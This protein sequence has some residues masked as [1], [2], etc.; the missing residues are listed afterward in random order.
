MSSTRFLHCADVHLDS[1]LGSLGKLDAEVAARLHRASRRALESMIDAALEHQ[2][3]AVIV[4]GDLFDGPVRDAGAGLWVEGQFR[5][6]TREG[7]RVILVLGN[8][9]ARSNARRVIHWPEGIHEL[10][11]DRPETI[12]L[13]DV[14]LAI[15]GQSFGARAERD[16]LAAKYPPPATGYFNIGIL[17]T[18][19]SG[20]SGHDT[21]APTSV[22]L[23]EGMGYDYWALGH[24]HARTQASLSDRCYIGYSG[25][26]QGRHIRESG[27]KGCQI[28]TVNDGR[29][30]PPRFVAT[31]SVRWHE[32]HL[33]IESAER[34]GDIEELARE[35][36]AAWVES[37]DGRP[38]AVRV[39]LEG[40]SALHA[41]LTATGTAERLGDVLAER[42]REVG[43]IW[44]ES[45]RVDSRPARHQARADAI[46]ALQSLGGIVREAIDDSVTRDE[47]WKSLDTLIPK[48]RSELTEMGWPLL[49]PETAESEFTRL[50]RR[51]EDLLTARLLARSPE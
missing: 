7:I 41:E 27:A 28:V 16:D 30:Q 12:F 8:H 47:L 29:M 32:A 5:R 44:L 21:Y 33:D 9:D 4:A 15:H 23:L 25:N 19:L 10:A 26:T 18:S 48:F 22:D 40:S 42:L 2:V 36:A 11:S 1:P 24:I 50:L 17:H 39:R 34:L 35:A 31:D 45:V 3:A 14:G 46:P 20:T 38:L 43:D 13:D 49:R 37:S 6:L 51:A